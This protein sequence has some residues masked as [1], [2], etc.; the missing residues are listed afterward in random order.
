MPRA[1]LLAVDPVFEPNSSATV[2][3]PYEAPGER[4]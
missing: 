4:A 3:L 2:E 1:R